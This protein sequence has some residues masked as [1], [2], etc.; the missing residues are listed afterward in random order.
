MSER[1]PRNSHSA[2]CSVVGSR[3]LCQDISY[4][5]AGVNNQEGIHGKRSGLWSEMY[6]I[7]ST[8]KPR[9]VIA[10]NVSALVK[11]GLN[12]VIRQLAEIGYTVEWHTLLA[13]SFG[14]NHKR[15]R[16]FVIAYD[17]SLGIQGLWPE[18]F[19]IPQSLDQEVLSVCDSNGQWKVEPDIR[20][21]DDG[22]SNRSHR[23]KCLGNA[24]IPQIVQVIGERIMEVES[25]TRNFYD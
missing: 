23:L 4:C 15:E 2:T 20:R 24:V 5:G 9:W 1:T 16:T 22:I 13:T 7:I 14:A 3:R 6:R 11:R 17:S 19:K 18:G 8:I 12:I 10:E 25:G 21:T